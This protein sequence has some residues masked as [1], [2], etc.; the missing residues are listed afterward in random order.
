MPRPRRPLPRILL[1][2]FEPFGGEVGNPAMQLLPAFEGARIGD[3]R[4]AT[5][6]LPVVFTDALSAL[7]PLLDQHAPAIVLAL[8]QASGRARLSLERVALNL[9]DARIPDNAG[10]QPI[11]VAAVADAPAAYFTTLPVKAMLHAMQ[12]QGLP[13]E[14]SLSAGSYVC[15]AV[16]Y[17]LCHL[18]ATRHP[19]TR[20]GFMHLPLLPGQ[21]ATLAGTPSMALETMRLGVG[22]ALETALAHAVDRRDVGGRIC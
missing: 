16:F 7:A 8:G 1:T 21:A 20:T 13:A 6:L 12:A 10:A 14:L 18:A 3:H 19:A 2:G 17:A 22:L 9:I 11:D 4:V 15:N 5:A